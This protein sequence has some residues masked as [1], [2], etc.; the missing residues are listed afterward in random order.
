MEQPENCPDVL[1][2][3]MRRTWN[4]R[5]TKRPTF[6][7]IERM[8]LQGVNI[9]DFENVSFYHNPEG[10]EARNQNSLHLQIEQ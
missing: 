5:A 3:L 2:N 7:C 10:I 6:I 4:Q 9:K 8:L 1:Y